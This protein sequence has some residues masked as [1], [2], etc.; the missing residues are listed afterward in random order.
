MPRPSK[1]EQE[2]ERFRR[3][4]HRGRVPRGNVAGGAFLGGIGGGVLAFAATYGVV[5]GFAKSG[6]GERVFLYDWLHLPY[7]VV[8]ILVTLMALGM[9][10]GAEQIEKWMARRAEKLE[11]KGAEGGSDTQDTSDKPPSSDKDAGAD[12][13]ASATA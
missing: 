8:A 3:E 2:F 1:E 13:P 7:G 4:R 6:S 11:S 9:F 12:H 5:G 10:A